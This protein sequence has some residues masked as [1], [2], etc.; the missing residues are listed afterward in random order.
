MD[1]KKALSQATGTARRAIRRA[2]RAGRAAG[3]LVRGKASAVAN[4]S[5]E[6]KP[7]NDADLKAKVE[8][9][10][11]RPAEVPKG[12]IDISAAHGVVELRGQVKRPEDKKELEAEVRKIAEV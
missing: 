8:S 10:V 5:R 6:P 9:Q 4:R 3:S 2:E 7:L 1:S 11:F 12:S